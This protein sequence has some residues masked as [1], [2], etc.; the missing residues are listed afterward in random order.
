MLQGPVCYLGERTQS[1]ESSRTHGWL[2]NRHVT[3]NGRKNPLE[4]QEWAWDPEG[5]VRAF[6]SSG[7][8][9]TAKGCLDSP[10]GW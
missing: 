3:L 6:S 1:T 4:V 10:M 7:A 9:D 8:A 2:Q 5:L